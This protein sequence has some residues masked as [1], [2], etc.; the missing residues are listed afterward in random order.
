MTFF[1]R[2]R[3]AWKYIFYCSQLTSIPVSISTRRLGWGKRWT[4]RFCAQLVLKCGSTFAYGTKCK[5][6]SK[7]IFLG[8]TEQGH[9]PF[10]VR[11][12]RRETVA[13]ARGR[14]YS[15]SFLP[16]VTFVDTRNIIFHAGLQQSRWVYIYIYIS[17]TTKTVFSISV[18]DYDFH[19]LVPGTKQQG[20]KRKLI[21][22]S[23]WAKK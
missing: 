21:F 14:D 23:V 10:R 16:E 12:N 18:Q 1:K 7:Y 9:G 4:S 19:I 13:L 5:Q 22:G 15:F 6:I 3:M 20:L 17:E 8:F 2:S 11:V